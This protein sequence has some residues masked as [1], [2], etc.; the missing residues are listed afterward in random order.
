MAI[1]GY[2]WAASLHHPRAA[3]P[4]VTPVPVCPH[5]ITRQVRVERQGH[6]GP[7]WDKSDAS[8]SAQV[9][10]SASLHHNSTS[11]SV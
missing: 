1:P 2:L 5:P 4:K 6:L 9:L 3:S 11:A 7:M 8:V 10:G